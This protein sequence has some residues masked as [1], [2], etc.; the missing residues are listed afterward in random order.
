MILVLLIAV[1]NVLIKQVVVIVILINPQ[2]LAGIVL[3]KQLVLVIL[4]SLMDV[5]LLNGVTRFALLR[6][7]VLVIRYVIVNSMHTPVVL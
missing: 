1:V 3:H 4:T 5:V 6:I 2:D 7:I